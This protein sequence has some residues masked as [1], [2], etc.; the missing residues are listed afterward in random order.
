MFWRRRGGRVESIV[1]INLEKIISFDK[2][3]SNA[4]ILI[5]EKNMNIIEEYS[6]RLAS[7]IDKKL[8]PKNIQLILDGG[9]FNGSYMVGALFLLRELQRTKKTK[10]KKISGCSVGAICGLLYYIDAL[11]LIEVYYDSIRT[12]LKQHHNT[13]PILN[14]KEMIGTRMPP[15]VCDIVNGKLYITYYDLNTNRQKTRCRFKSADHLIQTILYSL[16]V[17]YIVNGKPSYDGK[18]DGL[19]AYMFSSKDPKKTKTMYIN[20]L[21]YGRI[22]GI[23]DVRN[24]E[25]NI[26]RILQGLLELHFFFIKEQPTPMF[27]YVED[28]SLK[29][30][31]WMAMR[32]IIEFIISIFLYICH[33]L[34]E[35]N[36]Y[37]DSPFM[38]LIADIC[39]RIMAFV[40][41]MYFL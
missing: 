3:E 33:Q 32:K 28:W 7:N 21:S 40:L 2:C 38:M 39:H 17:P 36:I 26:H 22:S 31:G 16:F 1:S 20:L 41:D 9:M 4:I 10:I 35:K 27:S 30:K 37:R 25:K 5:F 15:N 8:I 34:N 29:D 13:L 19:S 11:D 12:H 18:C 23:L 24:E 6:R 14:L